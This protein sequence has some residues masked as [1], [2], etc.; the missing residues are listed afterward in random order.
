[1]TKGKLTINSRYIGKNDCGIYASQNLSFGDLYIFKD[2]V[3]AN[4]YEVKIY[5]N[6]VLVN[7]LI[8][9]SYCNRAALFDMI[10]HRIYTP[11]GNIGFA[12]E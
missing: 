3:Y 10:G 12:D 1:M 7:Y 4:V 5:D 8:P 9:M 2:G 6:N 11:S